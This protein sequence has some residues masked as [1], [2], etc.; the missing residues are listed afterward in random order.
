MFNKLTLLVLDLHHSTILF[1]FYCMLHLHRLH[2]QQDLTYMVIKI[3]IYTL[4]DLIM[5]LNINLRERT[6][7]RSSDHVRFL[8]LMMVPINHLLYLLRFEF[9]IYNSIINTINIGSPSSSNM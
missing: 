2:D 7:H 5:D 1:S 9:L 4:L 8:T 6:R 3:Y